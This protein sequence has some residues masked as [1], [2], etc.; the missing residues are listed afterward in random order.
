MLQPQSPPPV[1]GVAACESI[2]IAGILDKETTVSGQALN[3]RQSICRSDE[4]VRYRFQ[5]GESQGAC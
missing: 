2:D 4:G 5:S 1:A 3:W